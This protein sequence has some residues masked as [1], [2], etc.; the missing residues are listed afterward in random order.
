MGATQKLGLDCSSA[1]EL[2]IAMAGGAK[3][4]SLLVHGVNKSPQDLALAKEHAGTLVVDNLVE[5]ER[6]VQLAPQINGPFPELWLRLRPGQTVDT[7]AYIRTGHT[8]SKF[9]M[10]IDEA[11][12]AVRGCLEAGLPL[13]GLHFHLGSRL[14]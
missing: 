3:R 7:H 8:E 4:Q 5:L 12:Q 10:D 11:A 2:H 9:G 13:T 6:L 14:L 1:G